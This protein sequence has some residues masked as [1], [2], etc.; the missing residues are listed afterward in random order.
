MKRQIVVLM[1]LGVLSAIWGQT[2]INP[3][4]LDVRYARL[5]QAVQA[6]TEVAFTHKIAI[7]YTPS[8]YVLAGDTLKAFVTCLDSTIYVTDG[9]MRLLDEDELLFA[10]IG[11]E[12]AHVALGHT[13]ID[14]SMCSDSAIMTQEKAADSM[15][16]IY[17]MA[18][19]IDPHATVK[20]LQKISSVI[21]DPDILSELSTRIQGLKATVDR[22]TAKCVRHSDE[23]G[24]F[25]DKSA[26]TTA[27]RLRNQ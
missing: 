21:K 3:T 13:E 27:A 4:L 18:L 10:L 19:D 23:I 8:F 11:H 6:V 1:A 7:S 16:V 5:N 17:L 20:L 9:M 26:S 25:N 22:M 15:S 14:R 2:I 12:I 24:F